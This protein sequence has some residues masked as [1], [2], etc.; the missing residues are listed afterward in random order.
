M[1]METSDREIVSNLSEEE[2]V[3][4]TIADDPIAFDIM[5]N[6]IY[7]KKI[8]AVLREL[9]TNAFDENFKIAFDKLISELSQ[10]DKEMLEIIYEEMEPIKQINQVKRTID[11]KKTLH[12]L[13]KE[14]EN[15][16]PTFE[17]VIAVMKP[18]EVHL[19]NSN[20]PWFSVKDEGRGM[21]DHFAKTIF[22][23]YF[24]SDKRDTNNL[25]GC[26][27]LGSK[28]PFCY[29]DLFSV[30]SIYEGV[31]RFYNFQVT[32]EG[33]PGSLLMNEEA[34][35]EH[36]GVTIEIA[37][38][39]EDF[40]EFTEV[41]QKVYNWFAVKPIIEG[42]GDFKYPDDDEFIFSND[43]YKVYAARKGYYGSKDKR[44]TSIVMS[45][46]AYPIRDKDFTKEMLSEITSAEKALLDHGMII[47][48]NPGDVQPAASREAL[49]MNGHTIKILK[50][51]ITE[52]SDN[53]IVDVQEK[54]DEAENIW[55]AAIVLRT[56]GL[57]GVIGTIVKKKK[58]RFTYQGK[59]LFHKISSSITDVKI[60]LDAKG[61]K[62]LHD[63]VVKEY[64]P[65]TD[66]DYDEEEIEEHEEE[67][68]QK[69]FAT[70][71]ET[72]FS[73]IELCSL[74]EGR[75]KKGR[76]E[77]HI[78]FCHVKA[79]AIYPGND[80][81]IIINDLER[82][83]YVRVRKYLEDRDTFNAEP[84]VHM[85][86]AIDEYSLSKWIEDTG[87][88]HCKKL[89]KVSELE[90]PIVVSKPSKPKKKTSKAVYSTGRFS[91]HNGEVNAWRDIEVDME[92][93]SSDECVYVE[94]NR[95]SWSAGPLT[96][97][98]EFA[99]SSH[100]QVFYNVFE[101]VKDRDMLIFGLRKAL[102]AKAEKNPNWIRLD[103][104]LKKNFERCCLHAEDHAR[105]LAYETLSI[106]NVGSLVDN[107]GEETFESDSSFGT[108]I[109]DLKKWKD[110]SEKS[111]V[112]SLSMIH[113][114]CGEVLNLEIPKTNDYSSEARDLEKRFKTWKNEYP[115]LKMV[116]WYRVVDAVSDSSVLANYINLCDKIKKEKEV[117][118]L[119]IA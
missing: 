83:S 84:K 44:G 113:S 64:G 114:K 29:T 4:F 28:S 57:E 43:N 70:K 116:E 3:K 10:D 52:I 39:S 47:Y 7:T 69:E 40:E 81:E 61:L 102:V 66:W 11:Q 80:I 117:K 58:Y 105:A 75:Y 79:D 42:S 78:S 77:R 108:L 9:S 12:N 6:G 21:T 22:T 56:I 88:N 91:Y 54:I 15:Y 90:A 33:F 30:T 97:N 92:D 35:D 115:M 87:L 104:W 73:K 5:S 67:L 112:E 93:N 37:V 107:F 8:E 68:I 74:Q 99:K 18:I 118:K 14:A 45:N 51:K 59:P 36:N 62:D 13:F 95:Y 63:E 17:E 76:N 82:G 100:L 72:K 46:V 24:N 27:G 109:Q 49:Q 111:E 25:N 32:E 23:S 103:E 20:E 85:I 1:K 41:A 71:T 50:N 65:G 86:K 16:E 38:K 53:L 26:F 119:K 96:K 89:I 98:Q 110:L 106:N 2:L 34:T 48:V 94:I 60:N 101:F 31:K 55:E 19:P